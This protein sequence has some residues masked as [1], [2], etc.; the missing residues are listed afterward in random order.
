M[1]RRTLLKGAGAAGVG[2]LGLSSGA[3]LTAPAYPQAKLLGRAQGDPTT[4]VIAAAASPSD[5]DPHSSYNYQSIMALLGAYEGL[6][7]L[8]DDSTTELE[9][10]IAESWESNEDL[11]VWTFHLRPGVTFQDGSPVDA[12]AVLL[13]HERFFTLGMGPIS[14][15]LRFV[16]DLSWISAP[17]ESTVVFDLKRPQPLFPYALASTYG[18]PIVNAKLLREHE[19]D[20]DW[21]HE[22]AMLNAEGIGSGPYRITNFEPEQVLEMERYDSYWRGWDGDHFDKIVI[23]VVSEMETRRQLLEQGDADIVDSLSVEILEALTGNPDIDILSQFV[24]RNEYLAM[25]V[26]GPLETPQARRA[27]NYAWPWTEVLEGVYGGESRQPRGPIP[28]EIQGHDPDTFQ[29]VTDLEM[30]RELLAEAGVPEGTQLVIAM[31]SGSDQSKAAAQLFQINLAELGIDLAIEEWDLSSYT[32]LIYG[33]APPEE[34]PNFM[35]WGW[36][37]EYNDAWNHLYPQISCDAQGSAGAN[38]GF[39]CNDQVQELL[40]AS[41][42]AVDQESYMAALSEMQQILSFDDPPAIYFIEAPWVVF[43]RSDVEGVFINPV[44]VGIYNYWAM[45]RSAAE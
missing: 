19:V 43:F 25:T 14:T 18:Q 40:G 28:P 42:D 11:S 36:W 4:L 44:N 29:Y 20:D 23:R 39:Y 8:K 5:L 10:L 7:G 38:A 32:N 6:I 15:M 30:A 24:T 37:P 16:E 26:S 34:R 31:Q 21:G 17:D 45:S 35:G 33:D 13:S 12:E 27:M 3:V 41:R 9:G 2:S 1:D 22:W